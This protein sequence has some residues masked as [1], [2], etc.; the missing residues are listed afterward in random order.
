MNDRKKTKQQ[1]IEELVVLRQRVVELEG[2]EK[3]RRRAEEALR[4]E[5]AYLDEL[6]EASPEAVVLVD[7]ESH[8]LR[9]NPYFE[10]LFGYTEAEVLGQSID[11][12]LAP[13]ELRQEATAITQRVAQGEHIAVESV[14][15]HKDGTPV[16]VSILGAP[17]RMGEGQVAVYGIY[18]DITERKQA[19]QALQESESKYRSLFESAP[20]GLGVADVEGNLLAFND[21]MLEP[22]GYTREDI[23]AI[24]NVAQL[25]ADPRERE[26]VLAIARE[27]GFVRQHEVRFKRKDGT[28][29]DALL[30][31]TGVSVDGAPGWQAMVEDV[32]ERKRAQEVLLREKDFSDTAIDSLPGVF[33]LVDDQ[34]RFV[35][36]NK[37]VPRVTGYTDAEIADMH[38]LDFFAS[39]NK[40]LIGQRIQEVFTRGHATVEAELLTKDGSKIPYFFTGLRVTLGDKTCL[41]GT[42]IDITER[43]RAEEELR[44]SEA[45]YR[46]LFE[47]ATYGIYRSSPD[48]QFISANPALVEMLGY[49]SERELLAVD[50]TRDVY[51]D[52]S[53]RDRL[54]A[55][56]R[57]AQR[58]GGLEVEWKRKN[59]SRV[60]VRLS[61]RP[62]RGDRGELEG[63]EMIAEDVSERRAL[64]AQ[65]RQAQKMEAIGQLTGGIAHDFNNVLT[66]ILAN[67]DLIG[68]A[69]PRGMTDT[70]ADL[71]DLQNAARRG[72]ALIRKLLGFSRRE[73]LELQLIDLSKLVTELSGVLRRVVPENIEIQ[74]RVGEH[75][76]RVL[77]DPGAVEQV[78]L[79]LATNARDAMPGGGILRIETAR[80][81]LDEGYRIVHPWAEPGEYVCL[82]CTDTGIGMDEG[83][84]ERIFE[85]FFTTKPTAEGTGLGMA[86]VYGLVKQHGGYVYIHSEVGQGTAVK[87]YVPAASEAAEATAV[88]PSVEELRAGTET[89]L[90]VEDEPGIRR[91]T[92]RALES[93]GYTV[94]LA[95]DGQEALDIYREHEGLVDLVISDLVMPRLGGRQLHEALK[96]EGKP[97][98]ILLTSGYSAEDV[99]EGSEV[100]PAVPFLH[101]PWTLTDL[102]VR[103]RRMLDE[104][105]VAGGAE[106]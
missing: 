58:V 55:Q 99:K 97:V 76:S 8:I 105:A 74:L 53:E 46:A 75:D 3:Q 45:K 18:R 50:P 84:K 47:H 100:D 72:T 12:L 78:V 13:R 94:W 89:I 61:G 33:Y 34:R 96:K 38:P 52:S 104:G 6:F 66:V 77:A 36:W 9:V 17:V 88:T 7:N 57:N 63:F 39:E 44:R 90:L 43:K 32:T 16:H 70:R 98:K 68:T 48:G 49:S 64:E 67:A 54:I 80:S 102:L 41:L 37:N 79:N 86:M 4:L 73:R 21:S 51:A 59:G 26:E 106:K 28:S 87:V 10:T 81:W 29:Y 2:V 20:I 19:E 11:E 69:L 92:K 40:Q 71:D 95:A 83:T 27:Q 82:T 22:G 25:Y 15:Q 24:G 103:V 62:V 30:S 5:K 1:L 42:G 91:A 85:P 93:R 14:R 60:T 31:L 101:K 65:L 35:R 23:A 56:Y